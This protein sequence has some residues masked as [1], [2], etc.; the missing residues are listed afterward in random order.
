M[1]AAPRVWSERRPASFERGARSFITA[2][3]ALTHRSI[4]NGTSDSRYFLSRLFCVLE[5]QVARRDWDAWVVLRGTG[6]AAQRSCRAAICGDAPLH[7]ND[8]W[9]V[10]VWQ[11]R[12]WCSVVQQKAALRRL[13]SA[14]LWCPSGAADFENMFT[15]TAHQSAVQSI[16]AV[17][18]MHVLMLEWALET[19]GISG[20]G[21]PAETLPAESAHVVRDEVQARADS[22]CRLST[23]CGGLGPRVRGPAGDSPGRQPSGTFFGARTDGAPAISSSFCAAAGADRHA[24][25]SSSPRNA[26]G[27]Q[28]EIAGELFRGAA[29]MTLSPRVVSSAPASRRWLQSLLEELVTKHGELLPP[30]PHR[31]AFFGSAVTTTAWLQSSEDVT[32]RGLHALLD[33]LLLLRASDII[34]PANSLTGGFVY[35][36]C[37]AV[38]RAAHPTSAPA[39]AQLSRAS[40]LLRARFERWAAVPVTCAGAKHCTQIPTLPHLCRAWRASRASRSHFGDACP[41]GHGVPAST[42]A[43]EEWAGWSCLNPDCRGKTTRFFSR[44]RASLCVTRDG[45]VSRYGMWRCVYCGCPPSFGR[46][47]FGSRDLVAAALASLRVRAIWDALRLSH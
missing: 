26:G 45:V 8:T 34:E 16:Q 29:R 31:T 30:V 3:P 12:T 44:S 2:W 10:L 9:F 38:L 18:A 32:E 13:W 6:S 36:L 35:E 21:A 37:C 27:L 11:A 5:A 24:A 19:G 43:A 39:S 1:T 25:L 33:L 41:C 47:V 14:L 15:D 20:A 7:C 22:P 40:G 4:R 17:D 23:H 28:L 42:A 46:T